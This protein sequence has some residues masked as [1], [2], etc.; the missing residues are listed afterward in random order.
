MIAGISRAAAPYSGS[1][2]EK[3]MSTADESKIFATKIY[4]MCLSQYP[5][6]GSICCTTSTQVPMESISPKRHCLIW[7]VTMIA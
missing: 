1:S 7:L 6:A 5:E 2:I 4:F 3:A